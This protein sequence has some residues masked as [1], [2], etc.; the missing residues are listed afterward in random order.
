MSLDTH[1]APRPSEPTRPRRG[2][3]RRGSGAFAGVIF[4]VDGVLLDSAEFHRRAWYV[5]AEELAAPMCDGFFWE[6]F[7]QTNTTILRRLLGRELDARENGRLSERKE[8]L[9]RDEARG[10]VSFFPGVAKMLATLQAV[11]LRLALGTS[12]PRSN[13]EFYYRELDLTRFFPVYVCMDDIRRG[14]PD[15]EVFLRAAER[16]GL[17]PARCVVVEDA[18]AGIAAA[19]AGGMKCVAVATTNSAEAL[20]RQSG[21]DRVLTRTA[22]LTP[23]RVRALLDGRPLSA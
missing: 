5:L 21:A 1:T 20:R 12:T 13:V 6:T 3:G 8:E 4:D 11:G 17:P 10:R 7:G 9:F 14:K 19:R 23:A 18:F 2:A 16:L 15:P 22:E